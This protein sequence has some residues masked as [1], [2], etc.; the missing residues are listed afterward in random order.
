[1]S[2][3]PN[4]FS[5][6]ISC[7]E[8]SGD[9]HAATLLLSL[10]KLKPNL[11][12]SALAGPSLRA[13]G[14]CQI[15]SIE[16]LSVMG[17][18][19]VLSTIPRALRILADIRRHLK[20]A[21]PAAVILVD[22]PEFNFRVA[23]IAF[24]LGIPT[25]YY[26]SPKLWAWRTGRVKF[27]K[28]YVRKV[29]S[30]LPFEVA[31]YAG[32]G[33]AVEYV[34]NPLLDIIDLPALDTVE[35]NENYIGIMPGSRKKE[36]ESLLPEFGRAAQILRQNN[37]D[38]N[39]LCLR[40][41]NIKAEKLRE[42]WPA[43]VPM[44]VIEPEERYRAIKNCAIMLAASGTAT[45]ECALIGTPT[46]AAY[47]VSKLTY[48]LGKL[49]VKARWMSLANYIFEE[50][51]LPELLQEEADAPNVAKLASRW[52]ADP[53]GMREMRRK[54]FTLRELLGPPGAADRAAAAIL[55]D[56]EG[57]RP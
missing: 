50:T 17:F 45:L 25:Y 56:L 6:F 2:Q 27:L 20:A 13:A 40:A 24:E 30:I 51:I 53:A 19:E 12:C 14:A 28:K 43:A 16:E 15:H 52:L 18:T 32:H 8:P 10:R 23:R 37:P 47:K 1:M 29:I 46:I 54:L 39:F 11:T 44:T 22:A 35:I 5:V 3:A 34:G 48:S 26:I 7:G 33:M 31:F 4:P 41:P 21:R 9:I 38:L 49:V 57:A 36:I 42:L 55:H